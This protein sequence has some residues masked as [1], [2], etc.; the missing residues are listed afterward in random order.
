MY[1]FPFLFEN[2]LVGLSFQVCDASNLGCNSIDF[3][4]H[5]IVDDIE[6]KNSQ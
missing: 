4:A 6:N 2:G 3:I 1:V 5:I